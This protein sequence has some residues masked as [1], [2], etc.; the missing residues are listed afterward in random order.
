MKVLNPHEAAVLRHDATKSLPIC[1]GPLVVGAALRFLGCV[2]G[3][4][5][6]AK[7][8]RLLLRLEVRGSD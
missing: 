4:S 1:Q 7:P 6:E 2:N 3:Y 8:N 5:S